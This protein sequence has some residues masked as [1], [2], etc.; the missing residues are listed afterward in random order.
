MEFMQLEPAT[1]QTSLGQY[2][3]LYPEAAK[4]TLMSLFREN[5]K[6]FLDLLEDLKAEQE[7]MEDFA[8]F[9][10]VFRALA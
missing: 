7:I 5:P 6:F 4:K 10:D 9:D 3:N 2:F 8:E 1:A